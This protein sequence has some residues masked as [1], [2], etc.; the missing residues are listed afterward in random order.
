MGTR[1]GAGSLQHSLYTTRLSHPQAVL[2]HRTRKK[3]NTKH[4]TPQKHN[5]KHHTPP[6]P[7]ESCTQEGILTHW[8]P[9]L[10][11]QQRENGKYQEFRHKFS[12]I[13]WCRKT[14]LLAEKSHR[15]SQVYHATPSHSCTAFW[16]SQ[17]R[18]Q[19]LLFK[20]ACTNEVLSSPSTWK[21]HITPC[22]KGLGRE[23]TATFN[24]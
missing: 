12:C 18:K 24:F 23:N 8:F 13:P 1:G 7:V 3:K 2:R 15:N 21:G 4:H 22:F 6:H 17:K 9:Q 16:G 19:H 11:I 14:E 5:H 10:V 20:S